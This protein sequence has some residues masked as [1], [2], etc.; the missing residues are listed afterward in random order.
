[1][2][3]HAFL[4]VNSATCPSAVDCVL[5]VCIPPRPNVKILIPE[6]MACGG[7]AFGRTLVMKAELSWMGLVSLWKGPHRSS[8]P[9]LPWEEQKWAV[10][11]LQPGRGPSL[12]PDHAGTLL[13]NFEP[14]ER[15]AVHFCCLSARQ[16]LAFCYS[17]LNWLR[18]QALLCPAL[19]PA[20]G[21]H[22]Y[23]F[24]PIVL[25]FPKCHISE[26]TL[27]LFWF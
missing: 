18:Q 23:V 27:I 4:F 21:N 6:L 14:P 5:N 26:I 20:S 12:E 2:G 7:G 16:S 19:F 15:W 22:S 3:T 10:G 13:L 11:S 8:R 24:C 9:L 1:M 17:S 25:P